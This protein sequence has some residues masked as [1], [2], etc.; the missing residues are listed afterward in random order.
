MLY[1]GNASS[2]SVRDAMCRG[3]LGQM[4]TPAE[5][6]EPLDGVPYGAD[7]GCFSAKGSIDPDRWLEWLT[8]TVAGREHLC[9]FAVAPD[10]FNPDLG[11]D[12]GRASLHHSRKYLADIR[13]LGVPA[14]VV[15]QNGL[16]PNLLAP[17]WHEFDVLFLGG[18]L[19]CV[20]CAW[21]P[22][23]A[24]LERMKTTKDYRCP[25]CRHGLTEWK[26]GHVAQR[27]ARTAKPE[28]RPD[29]A[30]RLH[31]GRLNSGR[32]WRLAEV[33]GCDTAD[34]TFLA[35]GPDKNLDRMRSW[36]DDNLFTRDGAA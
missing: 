5:G 20:P 14:A 29:A 25:A 3:D 26:L 27:L 10:L 1:L 11:G 31:M 34:G 2:P 30:K 16:T 19:E 18:C 32:R 8:R 35:H 6:R 12:M 7:N 13:A 24:D 23:V 36:P 9:L 33:M 21:V 15:A 28:F 4:V 17:Y 22:T